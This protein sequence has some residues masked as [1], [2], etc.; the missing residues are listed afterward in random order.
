MVRV[1]NN[2]TLLDFSKVQ[3]ASYFWINQHGQ[4]RHDHP[5]FQTARGEKITDELAL[6]HPL[7]PGET[8]L[9]RAN[10][11]NLIDFWTPMAI[12]QLTANHRITYSGSVA[13]KI[14]RAYVARLMKKK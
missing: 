6:F 4:T 7:F 13:Q 5:N 1:P 2:K 14:W 8:M 12:F 3:H 11:L 10:R 9:Q